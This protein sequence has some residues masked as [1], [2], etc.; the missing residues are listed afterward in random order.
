LINKPKPTPVTAV[1]DIGRT[2]KKFLLFDDNFEVV[3]QKY[4][5]MKEAEETDD[6]GYPCENLAYLTDWIKCQL[7]T[8]I[9]DENFNIQALNFSAYGA[10]LVHLDDNGSVA[11]P[12]YNYLKPYPEDLLIQFYKT[13]GG[14]EQFALETASPPMG[15]L[16]SGLQL[17]WLKYAKPSL[18][19]NIGHT[20]HFPQY[21]SAIFTGK[22]ATE[23]TSIGC[24]T[25]MWNYGG[26]RYHRWLKQ[27]KMLHLLPEIQPVTHTNE[28][29]FKGKKIKTGIGMHDSSAALLP[30]LWAMDDPFMLLSTGTWSIALNPFNKNPLT[31]EELKRD[32]LCFMNQAGNQVKAARFFLGSEY[33][34][35][36][37]KLDSYF[38]HDSNHTEIPLNISLLKKIIKEDNTAKKLQLET[39]HTSGPFRAEKPG[40]WQPDLFSSYEEAYHQLM[41]DLAAIQAVSI[42]MAEGPKPIKKIIVT[43]G[44]SS[45]KLF[46]K[47]LASRFPEKEIYTSSYS[48]VSALGAAV[49]VSDNETEQKL[50][51]L[52]NLKRHLPL[53]DRNIEVEPYRW[54]K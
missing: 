43:G 50:K 6:D 42:K 12:F 16:N 14:R 5:T 46:L 34:W 28:R 7:Q 10:S 41:I 53:Q 27:E 4:S 37:K 30:Y 39:A 52:L 20:L 19:K 8:A 44:F 23:Y 38:E 18:Y 45:N 31:F 2:N 15:T 13:Y 26:N 1:F 9:R 29:N 32:C 22:Y 11:I 25:A 47:V 51:K 17:Y 33:S 48:H 49:A 36:K 54:N 40:N 3:R 24:H 35:Q 21:L